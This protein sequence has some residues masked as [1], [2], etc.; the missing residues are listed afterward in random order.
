LLNSTPQR[1]PKLLVIGIALLVG[2]GWV[3]LAPTAPHPLAPKWRQK[4]QEHEKR[5]AWLEACRCYDEALRRERGHGPTR[6]AYQRCLR[7]L[8]LVLRHA[9]PSYRHA[10]AKLQPVQALDVYEE[11]LRVVG[12][13]HVERAKTDVTLLFQQGLQEL[14]FALDE[15][16][17]RRHHLGGQRPAAVNNFKARLASWPLAK[18]NTRSDAREQVLAVLQAARREGL[19]LRPGQVSTFVQEFTAGACNCLDEY[20]SYLAPNYYNTVQAALRGKVVGIGV[21]LTVGD[22]EK[23]QVSRVYPKG[24]GQEGGLLKYDRVLRID[25]QPAEGLPAEMAAER[26]RGAPGSVVEVEVERLSLD[27]GAPVK[28]VFKLA[29]R[30]VLVPSVEALLLSEEAGLG[31]LRI[32]HFRDTTA[33]ETK[34]ALAALKADGMQ[35]LILDLR[36]NPG[37][38]FKAGVQVADLFLSEGIIVHTQSPLPLRDY[39]RPYKVENLDPL[40]CPVVVLVDG[41]TASAAEVV[42]GAIKEL[43]PG[44]AL[45]KVVGQTTYGKGSIQCVIAPDKAPLDKMPGGI[46]ITVARFFS[47]TNQPYSGRGVT[48]DVPLNVEG[49]AALEKAKEHLLDLLKSVTLPMT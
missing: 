1:W 10:L 36:G 4:G 47:P 15:D 48:P 6:E 11:V 14:R 13:A 34:E 38:L 24:P 8:H 45:T 19:V 21:E 31:Y 18:L 3:P 7:R 42:A 17:F 43:R 22:D 28:R 2:L 9:D 40:L 26:L 44:R 32:D 49:E 5:G 12:A 16:V 20:T 33:Q 37:G 46:R 35:G 23:L 29:R 25:R 27:G 41:D 30:A 39:N